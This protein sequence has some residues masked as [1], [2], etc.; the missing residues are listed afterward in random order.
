MREH[1]S[2]YL[3]GGVAARGRE[4]AKVATG[5]LCGS[6]NSDNGEEGEVQEVKEV[7]EVREEKEEKEE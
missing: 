3:T 2:R 6:G 5:P 7:Q 4:V 1:L